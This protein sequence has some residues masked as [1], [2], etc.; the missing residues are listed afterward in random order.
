D[1]ID[2]LIQVI[3]CFGS[4]LKETELTAL[5]KSVMS[6]IDNDT[7][8][9]VVTKRALSAMSAIVLHFSDNQLN[10]FVSELVASFN[11]PQLT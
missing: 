1:A 10:A 9:T 7:A 11:S 5:Q 2:V 3:T 8:R 6:I 4:L